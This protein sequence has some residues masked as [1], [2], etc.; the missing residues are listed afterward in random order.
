MVLNGAF[1]LVVQ[2]GYPSTL[3]FP[4]QQSWQRLQSPPRPAKATHEL[5]VVMMQNQNPGALETAPL[6]QKIQAKKNEGLL[7][8][9][10]IMVQPKSATEAVLP[11]AH[12]LG[13]PTGVGIATSSHQLLLAAGEAKRFPKGL[14]TSLPP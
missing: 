14:Q 1:V 4:T 9:K 13:I 2:R 7:R 5:R 6:K 3:S 10:Q 11:M 8:P 12:G